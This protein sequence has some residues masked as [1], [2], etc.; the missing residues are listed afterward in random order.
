MIPLARNPS[1]DLRLGPGGLSRAAFA[2]LRSMMHGNRPAAVCELCASPLPSEHPHLLKSEGN[3]IICAC[4]PCAVLLDGSE[5]ARFRRIPRDARALPP[6][7]VS[8]DDWQA[9]G[10]PVRLAFV[11]AEGGGATFAMYPSPAGAVRTE[12]TGAWS[13]ILLEHPVLAGIRPSVEALLINRL[14]GTPEYFVA[15]IDRCYRLAGLVRTYWRDLSGGPEVPAQIDRFFADLRAGVA[16]PH[17][18]VPAAPIGAR[19]R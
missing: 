16:P 10:I 7:R 11:V 19:I 8:D 15:P 17:G 1:E 14:S 2:G 5:A 3:Q 18:P 9:M 13:A 6:L 4:T 12:I